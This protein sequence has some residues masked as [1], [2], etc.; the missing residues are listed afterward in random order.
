M[1]GP[2][3]ANPPADETANAGQPIGPDL[4]ASYNDT[5]DLVRG[6]GKPRWPATPPAP[7]C[8]VPGRPLTLTG[9]LDWRAYPRTPPCRHLLGALVPR[10]AVEQVTALDV[11]ADTLGCDR[12]AV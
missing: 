9:P 10:L 3:K 8:A 6:A 4:R 12:E 1:P 2:T 11:P 5:G 7:L